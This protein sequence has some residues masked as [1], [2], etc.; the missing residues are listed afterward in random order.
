[1]MTTE[2]RSIDTLSH[3]EIVLMARQQAEAGEP[4]AHGFKPGSVM[5]ATFERNH[6]ARAAE[7]FN[8]RADV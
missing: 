6:A 3:D 7:L 2:V 8:E 5:A 4:C 1:M